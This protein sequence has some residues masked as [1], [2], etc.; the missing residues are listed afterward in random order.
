MSF[1]I[2]NI[3]SRS[4]RL[5]LCDRQ[6][7]VNPVMTGLPQVRNYC[8]QLLVHLQYVGASFGIHCMHVCCALFC[9]RNVVTVQ[10]MK[11]CGGDIAP[12]I[13]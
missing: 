12:R 2:S 8:H 6:R 1:R 11:I 5:L 9:K 7:N 3:L 13:L 10:N 4:D